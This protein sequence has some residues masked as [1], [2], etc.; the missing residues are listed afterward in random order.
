[1]SPLAPTVPMKGPIAFRALARAFAQ[2]DSFDRFVAG[3]QSALNQAPGFEHALI[4]LERGMAEG[5]ERFPAAT[6]AFPLLGDNAPL[7]T[8]QVGPGAERRPFG[9][10][11]LHLLA[12]L[13]DFLSAVLAQA[14]KAQDAA[15]NRGLL[16][17][18]LN[19]A[20]IGLAAY[21]PDRRQLVANDLAAEW[22][23]HAGPPFLE[24]EAGAA[25][26]YHRAAGKLIFGEARRAPDGTWVIALHDLSPA[27]QRLMESLQREVYRGLVE[28][29]P[30]TLLLIESSEI[31]QGVM[32]RLPA[33]RQAIGA[34]GQ[35]GPYDAH[36]LG[37]VLPGTG[38]VKGRRRLRDWNQ[39]W[40]GISG[41]KY[42][43][44]ELGRDGGSPETLL[45]SA[46]RRS[47]APDE[48]VKPAVLVQEGDPGVA[49]AIALVLR[50]DYRV[51]R[52]DSAVRT[53]ELLAREEFDLLIAELEPR[54]GPRGP[55][56]VTEARRTQP[57]LQAMFTSLGGP[58]HE[59]P[60]ELV[61][62]G[63]AVV[64]KP[65]APAELRRAVGQ[66]LPV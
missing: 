55:E 43:W 11:D 8:L 6:L 63:A 53:R 18:L 47:G 36:R 65:F 14:Q 22:L 48:M 10:E 26:F 33:L 64:Q 39:L 7:G 12:G 15:R 56:L 44:A 37:V 23:G 40:D 49:A 34:E 41:L 4:A 35:C 19:Q 25:N 5:G 58:P 2:F 9:P 38:A 60:P 59:L 57:A 62:E 45:E 46:L 32:R 21:T 27:Q 66:R 13:A 28:R 24:L 1:M 52:S 17:F 30:V 42:S 16:R 61:A 20:P 3:L 31:Q 51:V 54:E 50:R 29:Q